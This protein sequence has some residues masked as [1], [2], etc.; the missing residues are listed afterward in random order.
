MSSVCICL[1]ALFYCRV[2]AFVRLDGTKVQAPLL[3][4]FFILPSI[5]VVLYLYCISSSGATMGNDPLLPDIKSLFKVHP[6]EA[7][8]SPS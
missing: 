1:F 6:H 5:Y 3:C 8:L 7:S 4:I 2:F